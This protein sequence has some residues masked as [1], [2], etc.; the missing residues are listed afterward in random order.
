MTLRFGECHLDLDARQ[1]FRGGAEV[2]LSPKGFELLRVLLEDRPRALSKSELL[3]RVWPG[4]FV[5]D[6]SL[7]RTVNEVRD[8]IGE[9]GGQ[10][11]IIR[12]VHRFGYA[13]AAD[14]VQDDSP[15]PAL[16]RGR[17][18]AGWL[19][20]GAREFPLYEGEQVVGRDLDSAICLE[21]P[22][23]SRQHARVV[24]AASALTIE[25]LGSKNGTLVRGVRIATPTRLEAG[26]VIQ[27]G[28]FTL[29]LSL[30]TGLEPTETQIP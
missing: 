9:D 29:S 25:D 11:H 7:A 8:G 3:E 5:S 4:V 24:M 21:S 10:P 2:H 13:F 16:R 27:I 18:P 20:C 30:D 22:K 26:D 19:R 15:D 12:T 28:S 14:V 6:A 17:R 1:L 23:V